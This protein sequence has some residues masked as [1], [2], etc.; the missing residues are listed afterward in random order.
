[1][2]LPVSGGTRDGEGMGPDFWLTTLIIAATPGTGAMFTVRTALASGLRHGLVA[3]AGCTLG[4]VPHLMLALSGAAALMVTVPA[5]FEALRWLGVAYLLVMA[6][7][8]WQEGRAVFAAGAECDPFVGAAGVGSPGRTVASAVLV[9]LLNPKL[10]LFLLVFLPLFADPSAPGALGAMTLLGAAFMGVTLVIFAGYA[11]AAAWLR[12]RVL[13]RPRVLG[14]THQGIA[15][16]FVALAGMLAV[17]RA[18]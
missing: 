10:A 9:N 17:S 14:R 13:G 7:G 8:S 18:A 2:D 6:W 11:G 4:I 15:L 3:A 16:L 5:L 12:R 1:M